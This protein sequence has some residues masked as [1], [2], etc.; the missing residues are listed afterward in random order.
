LSLVRN[1]LSA[2]SPG[3]PVAL[4]V[5]ADGRLR[6]SVHDTGAGIDAALL[7][8]VGE[9]FF[10]TRAPGEGLGLGVFLVRRL[11]DHLGGEFTIT[12]TV[13]KGTTVVLAL[14]YLV[15]VDAQFA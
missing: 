10:T 4:D 9:P 3:D 15:N 5:Q 12:S 6:I 2:S 7:P 11:A 13:G 14:P 1:A 8:R